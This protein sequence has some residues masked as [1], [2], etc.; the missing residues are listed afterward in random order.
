[1]VLEHEAALGVGGE[2]GVFFELGLGVIDFPLVGADGDMDYFFAIEE[3]LEVVSFGDDEG[4]VPF[5]E[6]LEGL[7]LGIGGEEVVEGGGLAGL[8]IFSVGVVRVIK[9]LVF[10]PE[11][12]LAILGD[13][14][15]DAAISSLGDLPLEAELE[16]AVFLFA[17]EVAAFSIE[18]EDAVF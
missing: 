1:M 16:V 10:R 14:V 15:F 5:A 9:D 8:A 12:L 7:G 17:V 2:G 6:G 11:E 18:G 3:V 13:A 4:G